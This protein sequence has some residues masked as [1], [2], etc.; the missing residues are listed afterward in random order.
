MIKNDWFKWAEK[1]VR[2]YA[3]SMEA[4]DVLLLYTDGVVE[5]LDSDAE[6]FGFD[7]L[8]QELAGSDAA[9][10]IHDRVLGE[11]DAFKGDEPVYDD[12]SLV[13]VSRHRRRS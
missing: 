4:G 3:K 6:P 7:R 2:S 9:Q 8:R 12:C 10:I 11:L 13:V 5:T 1:H